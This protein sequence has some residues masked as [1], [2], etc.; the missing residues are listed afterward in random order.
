MTFEHIPVLLDEVIENL[1]IREDGVY[2][3]GTCGGGGHSFEIAKRLT[4]G[5][6][7]GA[8]RD[9]DAVAAATERLS[10]LPAR[11]IHANYDEVRSILSECG[12]TAIDGALLDLGVSSHQLDT[13][14]RGFSYHTDA[15]L[16]MRMS[17]TGLSA[18]D[19]VNEY[20]QQQLTDIIYKY[21]E[22]RFAPRI[23]AEIVRRR[24]NAPIRTTAELADIVKT[25]YPAKF[26][27]DKHPAK[28][29]FQAVRIAVNDEFAHLE[30]ALSEI[31]DM[32][33]P[34]GRFCVITFHS[35]EDRIV[36]KFF[37]DLAK[38]CTC[39]PDFP[40]CVCGNTPKAK[41]ISRKGIVPSDE[42]LERNPRSRSAKLRVVEK[43]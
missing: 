6:L 27:R 25:A 21:G 8:D 15:P 7:I 24:E 14:E 4:T 42:E 1:N 33:S 29:T 10:G 13:E 11:V 32:L 38:G 22:E 3:D 20:S 18:A 43:C 19:I 31:F 30:T 28:Q 36:K 9:P 26:R 35:L 40:I 17:Q 23:A 39:P 34:G 2:F 37:A 5:R 41:L 16:D 12:E